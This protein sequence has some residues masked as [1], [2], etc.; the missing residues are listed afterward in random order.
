MSLWLEISSTFDFL[1]F[2]S[3]TVLNRHGKNGHFALLPTLWES[4]QYFTI[5][6]I[7]SCRF[8]RDAF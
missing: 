5:K 3:S 7:I 4:I 2:M 6:N 8:V 1:V